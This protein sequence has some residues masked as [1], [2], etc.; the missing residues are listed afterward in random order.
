[1]EQWQ[2]QPRDRSEGLGELCA[3]KEGQAST[4]GLFP[5]PGVTLE[6]VRPQQCKEQL[7]APVWLDLGNRCC[8]ME[9]DEGT[10]G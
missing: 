8:L 3:L 5:L 6:P 4:L 10:L 7:R 2:I 1:V 9:E